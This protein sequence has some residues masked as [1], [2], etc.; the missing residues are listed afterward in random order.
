M[1][2][3]AQVKAMISIVESAFN[4]GR[5][6]ILLFLTRSST[7][8]LAQAVTLYMVILPY[9]FLMNTSHNKDRIV[10]DG[11]RNVFRNL[12]G[13]Y[14]HAN[15][16][17][18]L[19]LKEDCKTHQTTN[20]V[21]RNK[22]GDKNDP[23]FVTGSSN[24]STNHVIKINSLTITEPFY[25]EPSTST[26]TKRLEKGPLDYLQ[27]NA[28]ILQH[29]YTT[30]SSETHT[31]VKEKLKRQISELRHHIFDEVDYL[32][33]FKRLVSYYNDYQV[34]NIDL[35]PN[36]D[37]STSRNTIY[38]S[39]CLTK[40]LKKRHTSSKAV[41]KDMD[42]KDEKD[43]RLQVTDHCS[44]TRLKG[45]MSERMLMRSGVLENIYNPTSMEEKSWEDLVEGLM[46]LEENLVVA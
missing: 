25:E 11:W 26:N 46:D 12:L 20:V 40:N 36:L 44:I 39:S 34:G 5:T 3:N 37:D 42:E 16:I 8:I 17:I 9:A 14:N 4:V 30:Y 7:G 31:D 2:I 10:A 35:S 33:S 43:G 13:R 32:E 6:L 23:I 21:S 22:V 27:L 18:S 28:E 15:V 29:S 1:K 45:T 41:N 19:P 24:E 38:V